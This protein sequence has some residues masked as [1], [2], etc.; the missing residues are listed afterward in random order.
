MALTSNFHAP[1]ARARPLV[2]GE[3]AAEGVRDRAPG[4][5]ERGVPTHVNTYS[6]PASGEDLQI[7]LQILQGRIVRGSPV[8]SA[9]RM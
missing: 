5:R 4:P 6:M 1:D 9:M 3:F 7:S 8:M 2:S